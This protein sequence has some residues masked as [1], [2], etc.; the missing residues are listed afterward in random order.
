M[1]TYWHWALV[2][3]RDCFLHRRPASQR[4]MES[5]PAV[6]C[7]NVLLR[8]RGRSLLRGTVGQWERCHFSSKSVKAARTLTIWSVLV[9][10]IAHG[11]KRLI[12]LCNETGITLSIN[13]NICI[14]LR[15]ITGPKNFSRTKTNREENIKSIGEHYAVDAPKGRIC[16]LACHHDT[17]F[18]WCC[19]CEK[20]RKEALKNWKS[21]NKWK[22][23]RL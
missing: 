11:H 18:I 12:Q 3:V 22:C 5:I 15:M 19:V 2:S 14:K 7:I 17:L 6:G 10:I 16:L 21:N 23:I 8:F 9:H 4:R 1:M 20:T 13:S